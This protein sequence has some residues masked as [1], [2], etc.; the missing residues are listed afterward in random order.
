MRLS[1]DRGPHYNDYNHAHVIC[2]IRTWLCDSTYHVHR[3]WRNREFEKG[4][5]A[6]TL[7]L[8]PSIPFLLTSSSI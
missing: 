4:G 6:T 7:S 5:G 3:Q 8:P 2:V 1:K